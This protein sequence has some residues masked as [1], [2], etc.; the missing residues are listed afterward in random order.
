MDIKSIRE[1]LREEGTLKPSDEIIDRFLSYTEEITLRPKERLIDHGSINTNIY[2]IKEGILRLFHI[3]ESKEVTYGF[4]TPGTIIL[5]LHSYYRRQPAFIMAENC[6]AE[7]KVLRMPKAQFDRLVEES[8]EFSRWMFNIAM[9]QLYSCE[10]KLFLINGTAK[11]RYL[12]VVRNR[13][14]IIE[15]VPSNVIASYLGVTPQYLCHLKH[16]LAAGRL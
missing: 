6:K 12:A 8:H 4:A 9:G 3:E 7:A 1:L 16:E 11:D 14:D 2:C 10:H 5:S 13:P 15:A